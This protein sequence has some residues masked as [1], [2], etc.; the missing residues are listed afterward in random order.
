MTVEPENEYQN[1]HNPH[2]NLNFLAFYQRDCTC[3]MNCRYV[4]Q[5]SMLRQFSM[6]LLKTCL[7]ALTLLA[8]R[9]ACASLAQYTAC[10]ENMAWRAVDAMEEGASTQ[11]TLVMFARN[12][13]HV[14]DGHV[15]CYR[16]AGAV[17]GD[18]ASEG[19][20]LSTHSLILQILA[21]TAA[22]ILAPNM[23]HRAEPVK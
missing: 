4:I 15:M 14:V 19:I 2:I 12:E 20:S 3:L 13:G 5:T 22:P 18:N 11:D 21:S 17:C 10:K 6:L 8:R 9:C 23:L 7:A 16:S 1:I